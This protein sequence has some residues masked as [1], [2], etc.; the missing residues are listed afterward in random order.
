MLVVL[1]VDEKERTVLRKGTQIS[2]QRNFIAREITSALLRKYIP[3]INIY[4]K[5]TNGA[6]INHR[7][8]MMDENGDEWTDDEDSEKLVKKANRVPL[9]ELKHLI[10]SLVPSLSL[11][12]NNGYG[13]GLLVQ[14]I[15]E[16]FRHFA[17]RSQNDP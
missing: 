4:P 7:V 2:N 6:S 8:V 17:I 15:Q 12:A 11:S 3:K 9:S 1:G 5:V 16:H 14:L 10:Q 13:R